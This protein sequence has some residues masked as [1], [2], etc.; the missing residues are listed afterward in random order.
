[1]VDLQTFE[2]GTPPKC[3]IVICLGKEHK[4]SVSVEPIA[5]ITGSN[6]AEGMDVCLF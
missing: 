5:G 3:C 4:C 2:V 6:P 1:M